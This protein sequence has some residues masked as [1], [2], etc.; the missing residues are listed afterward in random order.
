MRH[1]GI[2]AYRRAAVV[3]PPT[4]RHLLRATW[5]WLCGRREWWA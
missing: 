3:P 4:L 2:E 1:H 5:G